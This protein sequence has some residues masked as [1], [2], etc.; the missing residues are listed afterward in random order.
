MSH[1]GGEAGEGGPGSG[2]SWC[3]D[4]ARALRGDDRVQVRASFSPCHRL[5]SVR[6]RSRGTSLPRVVIGGVAHVV[7]DEGV[8]G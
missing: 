6:C 3:V 5:V 8:L 7:V 2:A 1:E 4:S